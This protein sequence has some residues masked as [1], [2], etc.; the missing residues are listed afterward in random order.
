MLSIICINSK[1][2]LQ[3]SDMQILTSAIT[4]QTVLNHKTV[5]IEHACKYYI[6]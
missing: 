5:N 3:L 1:C 2:K 6:S 4:L